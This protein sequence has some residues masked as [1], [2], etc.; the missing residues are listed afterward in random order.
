MSLTNIIK[1]THHRRRWRG[2][3]CIRKH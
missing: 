1:E 3:P 2:K